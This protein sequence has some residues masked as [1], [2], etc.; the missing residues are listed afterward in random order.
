MTSMLLVSTTVLEPYATHPYKFELN[1]A[2]QRVYRASPVFLLCSCHKLDYGKARKVTC[3][4]LPGSTGRLNK[5][6]IRSALLWDNFLRIFNKNGHFY[7]LINNLKK[8]LFLRSR[9]ITCHK[10]LVRHVVPWDA[11]IASIAL[12]CA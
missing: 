11:W 7:K 4:V 6:R 2:G 3:I 8:S 10:L 9:V 12:L 5:T 1:R